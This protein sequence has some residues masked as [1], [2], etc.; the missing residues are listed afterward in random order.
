MEIEV[1]LSPVVSIDELLSLARIVDGAGVSRLGISDVA[2]LRDS[3]QLQALCASVTT[4]VSIGSLVTNP[5]VRHPAIVAAALGTLNEVSH[6]RAYMGIGVGSGLSRI[7][8]GQQGPVRRLEEFIHAVKSLLTGARVNKDGPNYQIRGARLQSDIAGPVPV[9]IGTRSKQIC[10]LAGR[11]ADGVVVG[12]RELPESALR[13]YQ[14]WVREGAVEAGRDPD[15]VDIAPRMTVCIS[16]DGEQARRSVVLYA[17]H[18]L[19]LGGL[20]ESRLPAA[21]FERIS[22]L[23][24]QAT[25][26]YFEADVSYPGELDDI[27]GPEIIDR[28][29]IAG[30]PDECLPK[31]QSLSDM[32]FSTVSM[33]LAAVRRPDAT[34]YDGL[35]ESL[36][37]LTEITPQIRAL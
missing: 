29:A 3:Y 5:Y 19:S 32:G 15:E 25:A 18:Y 17:A 6:G 13:R 24:A 20:D 1:E 21:E 11:V 14:D 34:M 36:Q 8:I 33:G 26:W 9:I 35:K 4:N 2:L 16:H 12:A 22:S 28:F 10:R 27:V 37:G 7:G 30:T 31:L 23:V